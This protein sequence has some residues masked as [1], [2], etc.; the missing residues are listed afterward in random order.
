MKK[1]ATFLLAAALAISLMACSTVKKF[2]GQTDNSVLPGT[3]EDI[4]PPEAQTARDPVVTGENKTVQN[5]SAG[6][7]AE[8]D[9]EDYSCV[10][11]PVDQESTT[12]Q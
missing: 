6:N 7:K 1:F 4:L 2:T 9:P 8:C 5:K 11:P 10:P 12:A 3:R